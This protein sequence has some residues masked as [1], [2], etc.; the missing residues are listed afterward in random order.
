M[1]ATQPYL[2]RHKVD[3]VDPQKMGNLIGT[4]GFFDELVSI[5]S[6]PVIGTLVDKIN[7]SPKW[8]IGGTKA[9]EPLSFLV[10][11]IAL[12]LYGTSNSKFHLYVS[13]A[14]FALGVTGV[15]S[16]IAALLN[17]LSASGFTLLS[18]KRGGG[19][20]SLELASGDDGSS[21]SPLVKKK[22]GVFSAM[23]GVATGLGAVFAAS[24]LL[25][26][27]L[28]LKKLIPDISSGQSLEYSY[29]VIAV[30]AVLISIIV[31]KFLFN[32]KL[33]STAAGEEEDNLQNTSHD[34]S[35]FKL[36]L[37][38][39]KMFKQ[40]PEIGISCFGSFVV[41]A[42]NVATTIFI[43]VLV[44]DYFYKIGTCDTNATGKENC[45]EAYMFLAMLTGIAQTFGLLSSPIWARIINK[46]SNAYAMFWSAILMVIGNLGL[47]FHFWFQLFI[48][49]QGFYYSPKH[50]VTF[51]VII[52]AHIGQFGLI[53][54]SMGLLS[55]SVEHTHVGT[56][57]GLQALCGSMGILIVSKLGGFWTNTWI[58]GPFFVLGIFSLALVVCI[59]KV[60]IDRNR[61]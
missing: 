6:A 21:L 17:E 44:F 18:I 26:L 42:S 16:L 56:V 23:I 35:Y 39:Y 53:M 28:Y 43:P 61:I 46:Q 34:Q 47:C 29:L 37:Q 58:L 36:L 24:V 3:G 41:R 2:I 5:A 30:Y 12:V 48:S 60:D 19:Y 52:I 11:S 20:Q 38:G 27:P 31:A 10:L 13:R 51:L 33:L 8:S 55:Q 57:S 59:K 1:S 49:E 14:V 54:T 4:L 9:I 22:N 7:T 45:E 50:V 25:P 32:L 40:S 15:L